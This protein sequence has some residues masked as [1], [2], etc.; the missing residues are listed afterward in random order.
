M[1]EELPASAEHA[2]VM[3]STVPVGTGANVVRRLGELG[4]GELGYASN[5]EFLKEGSAVVD[6]MQPDRVVVGAD[7][8]HAVG[9]GRG[10]ARCTSR[11]TARSCAPTS[12]RPR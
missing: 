3:K 4:K 6:F 7:R 10:G 9:R 12:P 8:A 2:I 11:S 5:P 1:I